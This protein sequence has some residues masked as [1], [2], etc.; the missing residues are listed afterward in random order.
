MQIVRKYINPRW[1]PYRDVSEALTDIGIFGARASSRLA[2]L[3]ALDA[4]VLDAMAPYE[5]L[6]AGVG[7]I[8]V[9]VARVPDAGVTGFELFVPSTHAADVWN[10]LRSAPDVVPGGLE[11]WEIA[12]VEAGRPEWG[13]DMDEMTIP[14]E[15]NFDDL[16]AISYTKGCYTGQ[17]TVAR[18]H[19]RGH[20]NRHLRGLRAEGTDPLPAKA[21]LVDSADKIVG[22]VRTSI[23][24]PRIGTV[25][26]G[27]VRREVP[28]GQSLRARWAEG[29]RAVEVTALPF[30]D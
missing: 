24:S 9:R 8:D 1:A 30:V 13:L 10:W 25:A 3:L 18:V 19:F 22:E 12:R 27:M 7:E 14:Q 11:A 28:L 5:H 20:V 2:P 29:E 21:E 16:H 15:A 6:R 23:H 26:I 4:S 17:E